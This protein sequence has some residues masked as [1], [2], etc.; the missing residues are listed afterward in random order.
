[1]CTWGTS[2]TTYQ[3]RLSY[4]KLFGLTFKNDHLKSDSFRIDADYCS[5]LTAWIQKANQFAH[6]LHA[7][8]SGAEI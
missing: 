6:L 8:P 2:F 4:K 3:S 1:M 5:L 7:S